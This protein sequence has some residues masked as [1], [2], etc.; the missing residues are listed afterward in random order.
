MFLL[1]YYTLL[2]QQIIVGMVSIHGLL[3]K[4]IDKIYTNF[5]KFWQKQKHFFYEHKT[6]F[7]IAFLFLYTS[8]QLLLFLLILVLS[9]Y[10]ATFAGVFAIFFI[11]TISFEKICMESR[12]NFLKKQISISSA[13][14]N[15]LTHQYDILAQ[16]NK[17]L[18][19]VLKLILPKINNK[20]LNKSKKSLNKRG[21]HN[22]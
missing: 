1:L 14:R 21:G 9:K 20:S 2:T 4:E 7:D 11:A 15:K 8:E 13:E 3:F 12:Y 18:R 22:V 17:N 19:A 6:L 16:D 5:S 10:S